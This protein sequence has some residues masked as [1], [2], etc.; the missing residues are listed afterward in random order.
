MRTLWC[1]VTVILT[2]SCPHVPAHQELYHNIDLDLRDLDEH[3]SLHLSFTIHAP[4]LLV[5][6]TEAADAMYNEH[7][8]GTRSDAELN[9]LIAL[10]RKFLADH[11]ELSFSGSAPFALQGGLTFEDPAAIRTGNAR[12]LSPACLRA[13]MHVPLPPGV[14]E[15]VVRHSN[16]SE[17]RLHLVIF[18]PK[19][20]PEV[21][22]ITPGQHT[23][24]RLLA[25]S[26]PG[27]TLPKPP[28]EATHS[29]L[30]RMILVIAILSLSVIWLRRGLRS[31]SR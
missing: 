18:R 4:E 5:G 29:R 15:L 22:E 27:E 14:T 31:S 6:F 28:P 12:G 3:R 21:V 16:R 17:K 19:T 20:F 30:S 9:Q 1:C 25:A 23:A 10:S 2:L 7:W 26:S 11:F 13:T 24:V 8:L